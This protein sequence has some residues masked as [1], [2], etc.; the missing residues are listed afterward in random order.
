MY[1][2]VFSA[3]VAPDK[4]AEFGEVTKG[5]LDIS[6]EKYPELLCRATFG[7]SPEGECVEI[8]IFADQAAS[9]AFFDRVEREDPELAQLWE[10]EDE[11]C[12]GTMKQFVFHEDGFHPG[13]YT[14]PGAGILFA[15]GNTS[16]S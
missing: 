15:D 11:L 7:P 4:Q 9:H 1:G 14:R 8:A 5:I 13:N 16:D 6:R 12:E 2:F 3:R 10:R